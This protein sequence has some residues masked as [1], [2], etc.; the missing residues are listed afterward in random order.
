MTPQQKNLEAA[1]DEFK[2]VEPGDKPF[3]TAYTPLTRFISCEY[4]FANLAVWGGLYDIKWTTWR[5]FPLINIGADDALLF[6]HIPEISVSFLTDL[7]RAL[8]RRGFSGKI[9][10]TPPDFVDAHPELFEFFS[11]EPDADFADYI[12]RTD[13]LA[14]LSGGALSKKRNLMAQFRREYGEP[15]VVDLEKSLFDACLDLASDSLSANSSESMLEELAALRKAFELFDVLELD[16]IAIFAGD[17]LAGFAVT[18]VHLDGTRCVHFEKTA[19]G[20][21]G[22]AQILNQ[23]TAARL[24][25]QCEYINREQDLGL[26]G[27]RRAKKSY[28]PVMTLTNNILIPFYASSAN[29]ASDSLTRG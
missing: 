4:N 27:L 8:I 15:R 19:V 17:E 12:Y 2:R 7:S 14:S 13:S 22:A 29:S 24:A 16:G 18:S 26:P 9:T 10:Q 6:P 23:R 1:L 25:G 28:K 20:I 21:K 11:I 5:G 3:L